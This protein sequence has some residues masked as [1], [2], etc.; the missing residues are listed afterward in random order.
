[1]ADILN[2]VLAGSR[3]ARAPVIVP[4]R[5]TNSLVIRAR[6]SELDGRLLG[7]D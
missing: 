5:R 1:V 3:L 4:D 2:H 6:R 7:H